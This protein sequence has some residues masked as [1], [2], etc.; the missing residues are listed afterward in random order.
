MAD[1][2]GSEVPTDVPLSVPGGSAP[3]LLRSDAVLLRR[4]AVLL[5][6]DAGA[7]RSAMRD[8]GPSMRAAL[9]VE[10]HPSEPL[11]EVLLGSHRHAQPR[12]PRTTLLG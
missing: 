8:A 4:D 12:L 2:A 5:R 9:P 7:K 6:R 11:C 3:V 10:T 1:S